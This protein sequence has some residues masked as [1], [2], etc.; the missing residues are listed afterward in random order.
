MKNRICG[1]VML[2]NCFLSIILIAFSML[3]SHPWASL[4]GPGIEDVKYTMSV[5]F[6]NKPP[7]TKDI[8]S[9][10]RFVYKPHWD[11]KIDLYN[12]SETYFITELV[13]NCSGY[14]KKGNRTFHNQVI[15]TRAVSAIAPK[16]C[17][18]LKAPVRVLQG[19]KYFHKPYYP[20]MDGKVLSCRLVRVNGER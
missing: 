7:V 8:M 17:G 16:D 6:V 9:Y 18:V 12:K 4:L 14:E 20:D 3:S 1:V 13:F 10:D 5:P 19:R 2:R 15:R 11:L